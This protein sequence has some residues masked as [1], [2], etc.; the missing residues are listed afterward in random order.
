MLIAD[1]W[2]LIMV[3]SSE[4]WL[5]ET[6]LDASEN[7]CNGKVLKGYMLSLKLYFII[8]KTIPVDQLPIHPNE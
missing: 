6:I 7:Y 8:Y 2:Q 4:K 5:I 3:I 1:N